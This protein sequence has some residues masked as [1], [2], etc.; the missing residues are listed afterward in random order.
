MLQTDN[1]GC[2]HH[3]ICGSGCLYFYPGSRSYLGGLYNSWCT[4]VS[5]LFLLGYFS[6]WKCFATFCATEI[7]SSCSAVCKKE[8][9]AT[10]DLLLPRRTMRCIWHP[11]QVF[12]FLLNEDSRKC[13]SP[14]TVRQSIDGKQVELRFWD[15]RKMNLE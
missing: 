6:L 1:T 10:N 8:S 2:L 13:N 9:E 3:V 12:L 5:S 4:G 14:D 11:L 15:L 7:V